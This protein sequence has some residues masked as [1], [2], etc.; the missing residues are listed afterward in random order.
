MVWTHLPSSLFL[1]AAPAAPSAAIASALFLTREALVEIFRD[2][3]ESWQEDGT[4]MV[5]LLTGA[6]APKGVAKL[7]PNGG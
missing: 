6:K 4:P 2:S 7:K 3:V 5:V 1:I